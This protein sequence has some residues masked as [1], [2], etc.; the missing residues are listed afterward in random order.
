MTTKISTRNGDGEISEAMRHAATKLSNDLARTARD[1]RDA[2]DDLTEAVRHSAKDATDKA[3]ARATEM[4]GAMQ[5]G[6]REHP[7]VWLGA[8]AG[9]GALISLLVAMRAR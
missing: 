5:S 9:A 3:R 7:M 6:V 2:A 1:A 4:T 8:A